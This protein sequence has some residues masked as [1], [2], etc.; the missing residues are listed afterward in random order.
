M[1]G[2]VICDNNA[3]EVS[4]ITSE[5]MQND[6]DDDED[7]T[8]IL[9]NLTPI[10]DDL[11]ES[12]S[13][14][15]TSGLLV[16]KRLQNK[17]RKRRWNKSELSK[18]ELRV[19]VLADLKSED[20]KT[21]HGVNELLVRYFE[22]D[23]EHNELTMSKQDEILLML[24]SVY[25]LDYR[26]IEALAKCSSKRLRRV[27]EGKMPKAGKGYKVTNMSQHDVDILREFAASF[28]Y[29][30]GFPCQHLEDRKYRVSIL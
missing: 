21:H 22:L 19:K 10:L 26:S 23:E 6:S 13:Q 30:D 24:R 18:A 16:A 3:I 25:K 2:E 27:V 7:F 14:L 17:K 1:F 5:L 12:Q 15:S 28:K 20:E 9:G 4:S 8:P 11:D 29:E